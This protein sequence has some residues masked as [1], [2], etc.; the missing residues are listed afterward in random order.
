MHRSCAEPLLRA[1]G[2]SRRKFCTGLALAHTGF[3]SD[4][5]QYGEKAAAVAAHTAIA[6]TA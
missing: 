5:I 4:A 2:D 1:L 6:P 3:L